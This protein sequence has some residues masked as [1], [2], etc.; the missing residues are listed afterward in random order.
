MNLIWANGTQTQNSTATPSYQFQPGSGSTVL[1]GIPFTGR[2]VML[3]VAV[4]ADA[5]GPEYVFRWSYKG[6]SQ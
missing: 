2:T 4:A 1:V 6:V 3:A 5:E